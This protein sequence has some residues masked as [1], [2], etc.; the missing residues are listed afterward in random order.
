MKKV[1]NIRQDHEK[2]LA[3]LHELQEVDESKARL[4]EVNQTLI[5]HGN[6]AI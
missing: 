5:D 3:S 2:R 1:D 6:T 4:I